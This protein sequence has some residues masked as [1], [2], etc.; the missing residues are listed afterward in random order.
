MIFSARKF[1]DVW[2]LERFSCPRIRSCTTHNNK[3]NGNNNNNIGARLFFFLS[4]SL[5]LP[6]DLRQYK[7]MAERAENVGPAATTITTHC[8]H[9]WS[10]TQVWRLNLTVLAYLVTRM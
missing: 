6:L 10:G 4:F 7:L 2:N 9:S 3:N 5:A 8:S 1:L